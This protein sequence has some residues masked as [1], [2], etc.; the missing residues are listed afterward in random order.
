[1]Q[2]QQHL[3]HQQYLKNNKPQAQASARIRL[4]GVY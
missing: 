2:H 1:L 3:Q 4:G